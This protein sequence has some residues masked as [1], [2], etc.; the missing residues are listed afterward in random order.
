MKSMTW[1]L[2]FCS[3]IGLEPI[4]SKQGTRSVDIVLGIVVKL[5][6]VIISMMKLN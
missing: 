4:W 2:S 5:T 1:I 6:I 3:D